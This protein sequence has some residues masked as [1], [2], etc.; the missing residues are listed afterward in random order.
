MKDKPHPG[1]LGPL[2]CQPTYT[3]NVDP[4]FITIKKAHKTINYVQ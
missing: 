3:L 4:N 1:I 2:A